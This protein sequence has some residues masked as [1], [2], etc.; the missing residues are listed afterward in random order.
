M[1]STANTSRGTQLTELTPEERW[2]V[3]AWVR[4]NRVH[5]PRCGQRTFEVGDALYLGFLFV[6]AELDEWVVALTCTNP[7]CPAPRT[8]VKLR[9]HDFR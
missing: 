9:E 3:A 6:N 4:S 8:G 5:C 2:H 1:T 7:A